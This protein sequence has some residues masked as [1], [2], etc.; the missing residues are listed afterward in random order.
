MSQPSQLE[1]VTKQGY[2]RLNEQNSQEPIASSIKPSNFTVLNLRETQYREAENPHL[3]WSII[4]MIFFS[5]YIGLA[6]LIYSIK[7]KSHNKMGDFR[8]ARKNS[9]IARKINMVGTIFGILGYIALAIFIYSF[10][11][12]INKIYSSTGH[13]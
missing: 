4:N 10:G 11:T 6:G 3:T 12:Y 1:V 13:F 5:F 7:T 9:Y 2:Q 8:N